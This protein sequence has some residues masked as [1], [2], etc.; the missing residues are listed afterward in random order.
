MAR[1]YGKLAAKQVAQLFERGLYGDGGG[2]Y[3]QVSDGGSKSWLFRFKIDGRSRWHGLGSARDVES[4][5]R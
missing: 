1:G 4:C 3:L 2:L 5:R